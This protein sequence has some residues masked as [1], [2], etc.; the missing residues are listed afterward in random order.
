MAG[1][2]G[3]QG[4]KGDKGDTG[5]Q[6]PPGVTSGELQFLLNGLTIAAS[7]VAIGLAAFALFRKRP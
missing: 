3:P 4:D 1:Q 6:D 2:R 7:V 5:E